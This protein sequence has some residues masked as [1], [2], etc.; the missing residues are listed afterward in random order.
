MP[1]LYKVIIVSYRKI[2][3]QFFFSAWL[4][5]RTYLLIYTDDSFLAPKILIKQSL[6]F[7]LNNGIRK[8]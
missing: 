3:D 4:R 1:S 7:D 6:I 5:V 8:L 2:L